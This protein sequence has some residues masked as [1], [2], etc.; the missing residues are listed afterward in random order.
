MNCPNLP[1]PKTKINY[2]RRFSSGLRLNDCESKTCLLVCL[3]DCC[4]GWRRNRG[5]PE[6]ADDVGGIIKREE[7]NSDWTTPNEPVNLG[8]Q[9]RTKHRGKGPGWM[10]QMP[11][12]RGLFSRPRLASGLV[13][14]P[15][16]EHTTNPQVKSRLSCFW[17]SGPSDTGLD[18]R[19]VHGHSRWV[20]RDLCVSLF[21]RQHVCGNGSCAYWCQ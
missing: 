21:T 1:N 12:Y 2:C 18:R 19:K 13:P 3:L 20:Q 17:N 5:G 6:E 4:F 10:A 15:K 7:E 14:V 11:L 8:Q 16:L 9:E